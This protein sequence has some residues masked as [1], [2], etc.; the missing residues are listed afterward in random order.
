MKKLHYIGEDKFQFGLREVAG[1]LNV[2][3]C[4]DGY[5]INCCQGGKGIRVDIRDHKASVTYGRDAEFFRA[6]S[7]A[8]QYVDGEDRHIEADCDF[9][10]FGTMQECS[11]NVMSIE[12][13]KEFIRQSALMGY[14]YL[15][16]YTEVSY[17]VPGEPYFGYMKGRFTQ[18]ELK[19]LVAYGQQLFVELVPS[20][21]TLGHMGQLF[22]FGYWDVKDIEN[23]LR[24]DWEPTYRL[25]DNMLKS[26][27]ECY[28]TNR[29]N[30]GMDEAYY[31][32]AGLYHWF[33]DDS[34]PDPVLLYVRHLKRVLEIAEKYGFTEPAIWFDNL[35]GM[36]NKG[37][38]T[39]PDDIW[40]DFPQWLREQFP[41]VR[42]I[43]WNYVGRNVE[44]F[45]VNVDRI[46]QL[47]PDVSFASMAHGYTSF[48]PENYISE[49]LVETAREGCC[50]TGI[51]DMMVTWWG[52]TQSPCALLPCYYN[53][54][55]KCGTQI[56]YDHEE[57]C[58][59]LFGYTYT[60]FKLLDLPNRIDDSG[61]TGLAEG[62]NPPFYM[63]AD[64]PLLGM[65]SMHVPVGAKEKYA[66]H[67]LVMEEMAKRSSRYSYIFAFE[68]VLCRTLAACCTLSGEI[69]AAY[70]AKDMAA[71][72]TLANIRIPEVYARTEEFHEAYYD[73]WHTFN[74]S[75]GWE[76]FDRNLGGNLLRLKTTAKLLNAYADGKI[77]CIEELEQERLP[78]A[79]GMEGRV[80]SRS[81]WTAISTTVK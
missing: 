43:F 57:R 24:V 69:K 70:D 53:F 54:I 51:D 34:R 29:I 26:L 58:K 27:S 81:N 23:I 46:R 45:Q 60:E 73:Y 36:L 17:E 64:D 44:R 32:G 39:P 56:G 3:L 4:G 67:A 77:S 14:T 1:Q 15:E 65:M 66:E 37:Y 76:R 7:L 11:K 20:I 31:L 2:T 49:Q 62:N 78:A 33:V 21:Q 71:L 50:R 52:Y 74:K 79:K 19:E 68:A 18:N 13:L 10:R 35:F 63:M 47:T 42:M 12:G 80:I 9:N 5:E 8:A 55:E 38:I 75:M 16:V 61:S 40:K 59:F 28:R 6:F 22:K 30:L 25:L 72:R 41:K 48:A